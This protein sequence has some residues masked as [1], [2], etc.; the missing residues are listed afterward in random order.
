MYLFEQPEAVVQKAGSYFADFIRLDL[1][2]PIETED[3]VEF[4]TP[5]SRPSAAN[6]VPASLRLLFTYS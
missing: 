2:A 6:D 5:N 4:F 3:I 1:A